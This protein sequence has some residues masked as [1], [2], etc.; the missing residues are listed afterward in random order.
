M[1]KKLSFD[2]LPGAVASILEKLDSRESGTAG[3]PEIEAR[4]TRLERKMEQVLTLL[5]PE[6]P[7]MEMQ[8]VCRVLRLSPKSVNDLE[9]AGVLISRKEGRSRLFDEA[10]V[11]KYFRGTKHWKEAIAEPASR[12]EVE[13]PATGSVATE[14]PVK[15]GPGRPKSVDPK[16]KAGRPK[17]AV[18]APESEPAFPEGHQ[19]IDLQTA[20]ELLK[21]TPGTVY[22]LISGGKIPFYKE[23][24]KVYF[25]SDEL[26]EWAKANPS[27]RKA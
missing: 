11:I 5:A 16:R 8:T 17:A 22:H 25:L 18:A 4:L 2:E 3:A 12:A 27:R 13:K 24:H 9:D 20:S 23:G 19:R 1:S 6:N 7:T 10:E 14:A 15:R 21:R 26:R